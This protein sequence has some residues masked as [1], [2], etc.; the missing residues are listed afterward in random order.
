MVGMVDQARIRLTML[1]RQLQRG[2]RQLGID[3]GRELPADT[4]A[5]VGIQDGR[6]VDEGGRQL[7]VGEIRHPDLVEPR[8]GQIRDQVGRVAEA[9]GRVGGHHEVPFELTE[10]G[11]LAHDAQDPLVIDAPGTAGGVPR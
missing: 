5:G 3:A 6:Q 2:Q 8:D 10:Q 9:V 1:Q 11:F 4:A 7:D